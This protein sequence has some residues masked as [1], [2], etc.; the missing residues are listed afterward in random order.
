MPYAYALPEGASKGNI[1]SH[2]REVTTNFAAQKFYVPHWCAHWRVWRPCKLI[3]AIKFFLKGLR[4]KHFLQN[5]FWLNIVRVCIAWRGKL[6]PISPHK[7]AGLFQTPGTFG[8]P[9]LFENF[10]KRIPPLQKWRRSA[11]SCL[12]GKCQNHDHFYRGEFLDSVKFNLPSL[13]IPFEPSGCRY[14]F[15]FFS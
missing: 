6:P 11:P 10:W 12:H 5:D 7:L 2:T 4:K 3:S 9:G 13:Y 8:L 15:E 1:E 14:T